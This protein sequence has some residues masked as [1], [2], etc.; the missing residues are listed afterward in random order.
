MALTSHVETEPCVASASVMSVHHSLSAPA[1][2]L[3]SPKTP[4]GVGSDAPQLPS[5]A[6]KRHD[7]WSQDL[8]DDIQLRRDAVDERHEFAQWLETPIA[9]PGKHIAIRAQRQRA[10]AYRHQS[11]APKAPTV[12][13]R[14][15]PSSLCN[16][17]H[18]RRSTPEALEPPSRSTKGMCV[19][20][21][22]RSDV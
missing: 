9:T 1:R 19:T 3:L 10:T 22:V 18:A 14:Q 16:N 17:G 20:P 8:F 12:T 21:P 5:P 13:M 7:M 6:T 4:P 2:L 15:K 11:L